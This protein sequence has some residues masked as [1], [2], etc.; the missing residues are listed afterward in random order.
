MPKRHRHPMQEVVIAKDGIV[1]FRENAIVRFLLDNGPNNL[2]KIAMMDFSKDDRE[3]L[4]QLIGYSISG[5]GDLP[6]ISDKSYS[7]AAELAQPLLAKI[8]KT[9]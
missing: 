5:Y 3:Q 6:Y 9:K 4:A 2:N 7:E 8:R 1:R